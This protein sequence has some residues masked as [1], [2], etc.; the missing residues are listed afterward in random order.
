MSTR[1]DFDNWIGTAPTA[2]IANQRIQLTAALM[3]LPAG[4]APAD[5][6]N[7]LQA[8]PDMETGISVPGAPTP[9]PLPALGR[10]PGNWD[11]ANRRC[12]RI[13][14]SNPAGATHC[15]NCGESKDWLCSKGHLNDQAHSYCQDCGEAKPQAIVPTPV[16]HAHPTPTTHWWSRRSAGGAH[17]P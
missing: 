11:C 8:Y 17:H 9:T 12:V 16:V 4:I 15:T 1:R 7:F 2:A 3:G 5:L 14:H 6:A 10:T 13:G